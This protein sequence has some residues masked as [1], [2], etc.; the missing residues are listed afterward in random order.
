L[1]QEAKWLEAYDIVNSALKDFPS[2]EVLGLA[3]T[4]GVMMANPEE[5]ASFRGQ[6]FSG[7]DWYRGVAAEWEPYV[8]EVFRAAN[9]VN[10]IVIAV[11][12]RSDQNEVLGILTM[13][14][15]TD[16]LL[17]WVKEVEVG[18]DGIAYFVDHHAN[19]VAHPKFAPQSQVV[20]FASIPIIQKVL[21]GERGTEL[22]YN[23][24]EKETRLA[25]FEPVAPYGWGVVVAQPE[26]SAFKLK[27]DDLRSL[28][29]ILGGL[30]FVDILFAVLALAIIRRK[31]V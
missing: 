29:L 6:D 7:R 31:N 30:A 3:T 11:P 15:L 25:A 5:L 28:G 26:K 4:D 9:N 12:I 1:I 10:S 22:Q 8:S 20:S 23:S 14:I 21:R 13:Q 2:V 19:V 17:D 24:I 18:E 27:N 16:T